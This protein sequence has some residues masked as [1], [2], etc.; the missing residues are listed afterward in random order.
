MR[1]EYEA[2]LKNNTWVLVP[3][4]KHTPIVDCKWVY[5]VKRNEMG[6][7]SNLKSRLVARG[8]TQIYGLNYWET[9]A[10]VIRN[11][12]LRLLLAVAV[13]ENYFIEQID[14]KNAYVNSV[15]KETVYMN[16]PK[17]FEIGDNLVC[18]LNKSIYGL[19]Q[20]GNEWNK[21]LNNELLKLSFKRLKTDS[22]VY[23][24]QSEIENIIIIAVYV[25]DIL[26]MGKHKSEICKI[27]CDIAKVFE[28]D[29]LGDCKYVLGL[30]VER[31]SDWLSVNQR[32]YILNILQ[33]Y[34]MTDCNPAR[35]PL[36][37]G[38]K[39]V[40][41]KGKSGDSSCEECG[42]VEATA[43]RSLIGTL[44]FLAVSTRPDISYAV[45]MLS[46]F[47]NNPH[48]VHFSAAKHILRYLKGTVDYGIIFK[49][50]NQ[51]LVGYSD[52]DWANDLNDRRSY[53]GFV[54]LLANGPVAWE[55]RK[56]PTVA[57]S[58]TEAE[59][60]ALAQASREAMFLT[61]ILRE[62]NMDCYVRAPTVI[63]SDNMGAISMTKNQ[64]YNPRTKHIDIRHHYIKELVEEDSIKTCHISTDE[65]IADILTKGLGSNK[66]NV[67]KEH[68]VNNVYKNYNV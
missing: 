46:R 19:K 39:M 47:N 37:Q 57:L 66:H 27:K 4:P 58:S 59:Y 6:N 3:K 7:I 34:N 29:D 43:Y 11:S 56:Q 61:G 36:V 5:R 23:I 50:S 62:L 30:N 21:L 55:A 9:Y 14:V 22:C 40:Q 16:Q 17:G 63:Y 13:E 68:I 49:K 31:G 64:G 41:C 67:L 54:F 53:T 28:I 1:K 45:S 12:T 24:K 15:L 52:A 8:F 51:P 32:Q 20:S 44:M 18:K 42:K 65:M 10:P 38:Q 2:L 35:T 25:D 60:M 33:Q 48:F 26:I